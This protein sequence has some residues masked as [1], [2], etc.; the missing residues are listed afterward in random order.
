MSYI[1]TLTTPGT[2]DNTLNVAAD[3][4]NLTGST[5][6]DVSIAVVTPPDF[7]LSPAATSLTMKR[8]GQVSDVLAFPAQGG[9]SGTIALACSVAGPAPIPTCRISPQ[10][11]NSGGTATLTISAAALATKIVP[12]LPF[13]RASQLY[14]TIL[15]LGMLGCVLATSFDKKRRRLWALYLLVLAATILPAACGGGSSVTKGPPPQNYTVTATATS[16]AI[17]HSTA[18]SVTVQ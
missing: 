13:E 6:A 7:A 8:G 2:F 18:I 17:Q 5:H 10:S 4:P 9:F 3:Q 15:P 14:V 12:P 1:V 11:V 16:G